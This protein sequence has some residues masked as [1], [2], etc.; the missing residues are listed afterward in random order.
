M[1]YIIVKDKQSSMRTIKG[2]TVAEFDKNME[3]EGWPSD[4]A[5]EEERDRIAFE[6][7]K[8]GRALRPEDTVVDTRANRVKAAMKA[9]KEGK[10]RKVKEYPG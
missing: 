1:V 9:A 10:I 6:E 2:K 5:S 3:S 4:F 7:K 8:R